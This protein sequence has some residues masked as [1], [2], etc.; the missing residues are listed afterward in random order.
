MK[1]KDCEYFG[2]LDHEDGTVVCNREDDG[3]NDCPYEFEEKDIALEGMKVTVDLNNI[4]K[5]ILNTVTNTID[6]TIN[7]AVKAVINTAYA[8]TIKEKTEA[9]ID[10]ILDVQV[11]KFMAGSI[12]LGGGWK[13]PE[14][15][16]TRE[17]YLTELVTAALS[18]NFDKD[19]IEK[20]IQSE[21]ESKISK[22]TSS[23]KSDINANIRAL[24]DDATRTALTESVVKMLMDN[25]T[26][27]R[28]RGSMQNLLN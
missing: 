13:E 9:A 21:V 14:R 16:L 7:N 11:E 12:T 23:V 26:Y 8:E 2:G 28:L 6:N 17:E 3:I 10:R 22:L 18:K 1:C 25:E 5:I 27:R 20:V 4:N 15:T 24:F 19:K